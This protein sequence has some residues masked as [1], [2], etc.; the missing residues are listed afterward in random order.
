MLSVDRNLLG[1]NYEKLKILRYGSKMFRSE[2]NVATNISDRNKMFQNVATNVSDV[3]TNVSN[4][5]TNVSNVA[6]NVSHVLIKC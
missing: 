5:A 6:T 4:F 3:A 1:L 2:T